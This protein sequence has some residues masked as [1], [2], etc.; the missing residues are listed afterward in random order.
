MNFYRPVNTLLLLTA[1]LAAVPAAAEV[2][3]LTTPSSSMVLDAEKG[4]ALKILYYGDKLSATD[5]EN[6]KAA[7][8]FNRDAYPLYG[9]YPQGE[10][11]MSVTHSDGNMTTV[12]EVTDVRK[13]TDSDGS[14][15]TTVEM[16][17]KAYPFV[18]NVNYRTY[19]GEDVIETWV[20]ATNN[21]KGTVTLNR[22]MSG[23]LPL[24]YG[25][26]WLSSLYGSWANE[27]RLNQEPLTH[28]VK[29]IKKQG[30]PAQFPHLSR[31][32]DVLA[33]RQ[34]A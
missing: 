13:R 27:G 19:P 4:G 34:T 28:G 17:D 2:I 10:A 15:V 32:S 7:G 16:L 23:Y 25:N 20:D 3:N 18:V 6:I 24:R 12:M 14:E 29:M 11:A 33:R 21:E 26:V 1:A 31:R 9:N 5:L 8:S 30:R 22:F